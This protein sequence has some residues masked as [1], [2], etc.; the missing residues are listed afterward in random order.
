MVW[1]PRSAPGQLC[2]Y[3]AVDTENLRM[4]QRQAAVYVPSTAGQVSRF[5]GST[6]AFLFALMLCVLGLTI[7]AS[8]AS[9]QVTTHHYNVGRTGANTAETILTPSNVNS[10]TFG[11]L[12]VESVD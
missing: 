6:A 3:I 2:F 12:F 9:A 8:P 1:H 7:T 10:S 5:A 4:P 11:R